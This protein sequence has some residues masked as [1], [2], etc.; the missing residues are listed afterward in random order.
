MKNATL[1]QVTNNEDF[2]QNMMGW[3][4][5]YVPVCKLQAVYTYVSDAANGISDIDIC[6]SVFRLGNTDG[7]GRE[8]MHYSVSV[9]DVVNVGCEWYRLTG[10][11]WDCITGKEQGAVG[12]FIKEREGVSLEYFTE[13]L[14]AVEKEDSNMEAAT[15]NTTV[16]EET[17]MNNETIILNG[18]MEERIVDKNG[19]FNPDGIKEVIVEMAEGMSNICGD[20]V[21]DVSPH[22]EQVKGYLVS[23]SGILNILGL[24]KLK[25]DFDKIIYSGLDENLNP[26]QID[27]MVKQINSLFREEI[28]R[29]NYFA[30]DKTLAQSLALKCMIGDTYTDKNIFE[31]IFATLLNVI[32]R[33]VKFIKE[34]YN[35]LETKANSMVIKA[36]L[37]GIRCLFGA[38][39]QGGLIIIKFIGHGISFIIAGVTAVGYWVYNTLKK[40]FTKIAA[41]VSNKMHGDIDEDDLDDLDDFFEDTEEDVTIEPY[42]E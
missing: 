29:L 14:E 31:C 4:H 3:M 1:F 36:I 35:L 26:T 19:K 12:M 10:D 23:V 25:S 18:T 32:K 16:Q 13:E 20:M 42:E 5:G 28:K 7:E 37:K 24:R 6:E 33:A 34:K 41:W 39:I 9:G 38:L 21:E 8:Y 11:G 17:V 15:N 30:T 2:S 27:K 22:V 40:L